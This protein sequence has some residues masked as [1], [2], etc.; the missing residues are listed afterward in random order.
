[1]LSSD[2]TPVSYAAIVGSGIAWTEGYVGLAGAFACI[3]VGEFLES[4]YYISVIRWS[5]RREYARTCPRSEAPGRHSGRG[6][7]THARLTNCAHGSVR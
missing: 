1:M 5:R 2:E 7:R 3:A 4:S 6:L